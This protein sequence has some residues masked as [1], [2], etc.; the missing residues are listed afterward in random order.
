MRSIP[1]MCPANGYAARSSSSRPGTKLL[2]ARRVIHG[3]RL[4]LLRS[5]NLSRLTRTSSGSQSAAATKRLSASRRE[6]VYR[7]VVLASTNCWHWSPRCERQQR[8]QRLLAIRITDRY[9]S[10]HSAG[11]RPVLN[12]QREFELW[13]RETAI[14]A[15]LMSAAAGWTTA[16]GRCWPTRM[17]ATG[18]S[19]PPADPPSPPPGNRPL[20]L[21]T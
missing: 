3:L 19:G 21:Q 16:M 8:G 2:T 4:T 18:C 9:T 7:E 10:L 14:A 11:R 1:G 12:D 6:R 5:T 20:T 13:L 17:T 15:T